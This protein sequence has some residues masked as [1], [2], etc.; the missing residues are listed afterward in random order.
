MP[1]TVTTPDSTRRIRAAHVLRP[2]GVRG[3]LRIEPLGGDAKRFTTGL[4]LHVEPTGGVL[5]VRA[6]RA[7]PR[8]EVLLACEELSSRDDVEALRGAYLCVDI[9]DVRGLAEHE[10]FV[11]QLIGLRA[12]TPRGEMVGTVVDVEPY[13]A[14]DVLV[15]ADGAH[16]QRLPMTAAFV[17]RVDIAAG[18]IEVT[19]WP[20]AQAE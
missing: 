13:P 20:E 2:H 6:T 1:P 8:G 10:W 9:A 19:P 15:V 18:V 4:R 12:L 16:E 17:R 7:V 14:Q 11:H 5:T 3:E